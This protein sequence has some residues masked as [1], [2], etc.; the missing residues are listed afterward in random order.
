MLAWAGLDRQAFPHRPEWE[1]DSEE[2]TSTF[3]GLCYNKNI[4]EKTWRAML[5][6]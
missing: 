4:L 1:S 3:P 6:G 2:K 5:P